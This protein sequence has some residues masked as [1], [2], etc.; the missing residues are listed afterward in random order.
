MTHLVAPELFSNLPGKT[1]S[2]AWPVPESQAGRRGWTRAF[3]P[4]LHCFWKGPFVCI[5]VMCPF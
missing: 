1:A 2:P 4:C 3:Q 5:V